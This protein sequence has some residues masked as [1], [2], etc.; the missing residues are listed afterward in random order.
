[1][2]ATK[3][4][5]FF[6][7]IFAFSIS[8]KIF[9]QGKDTSSRTITMAEYEKA[10]SFSIK[11]L[12]KDTY[13]KFDNTYVLDRYEGK[14]PYFITGDDSM[15]KRIDIYRLIAKEGMQEL[16]VMIFYT[17]EKG[18]LYKAVLPGLAADA[19]VWERYFEDIH[20]IDKEEKNF[21]LKLSY[22]L[23]R[24]LSFQLYK[25]QGKE[26]S[27]EEGTYGMDICFPGDNEVEMA[28]GTTKALKDIQRG[29]KVLTVNP[30]TKKTDVS[31][32]RELTAHTAKNYAITELL[33]LNATEKK[34]AKGVHVSLVSRLL[35]ATPNHPI[36]TA[37]AVKIA[38]DV[39]TGDHILCLDEHTNLYKWYTVWNKREYAGGLQKVYNIVAESGDTFIMNSVM[40]LQKQ[41]PQ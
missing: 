17:N 5:F 8:I 11:D 35:K 39:Q 16:G 2:K 29:D 6:I 27:N 32:V 22:V 33:L 41:Q 9:A 20:S 36:K 24:E 10:K 19:K 30:V 3:K 1:M 18:K 31:N 25:A 15:K 13:V 26:I 40:V 34:D 4:L 38:G 12:D 37:S 23:S 14:K 28:D 7:I 21:V